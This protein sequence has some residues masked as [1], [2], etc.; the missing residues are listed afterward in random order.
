MAKLQAVDNLLAPAVAE[1]LA[2]LTVGDEDAGAVRLAERYA[3][4]IDAA[5]R[6]AADLAAVPV[7][8]D[9]ARQVYAL[10]K[11]VEAQTVLAELGPKLLACLESLGA[12]PA[13]RAR[14]KGGSTNGSRPSSKLDELRAR[15]RTN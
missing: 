2:A 11:R 4:T 14:L 6:L 3:A 5:A 7:D 12:T 8:E 10:S 9:T 13:A 15:R 1:T